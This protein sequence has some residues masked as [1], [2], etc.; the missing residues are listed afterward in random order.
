MCCHFGEQ[1]AL[2][3]SMLG[4]MRTL[5]FMKD[6]LGSTAIT[7]E[8]SSLLSSSLSSSLG[9]NFLSESAHNQTVTVKLALNYFNLKQKT[10]HISDSLTSLKCSSSLQRT[11]GDSKRPLG[12]CC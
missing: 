9:R 4:N 3:R 5:A 10:D 12:G 2:G 6:R 7:L 1:R 11:S 8:A